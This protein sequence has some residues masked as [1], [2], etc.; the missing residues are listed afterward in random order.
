MI[1]E[2]AKD[3]LTYIA[4]AMTLESMPP[5]VLPEVC[6]CVCE[7]VCRVRERER[8]RVRER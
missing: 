7:R 4:A 2:R 1:G 8:V 6:V 3:K 5:P